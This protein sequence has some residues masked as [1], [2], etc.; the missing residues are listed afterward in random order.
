MQLNYRAT[1]SFY[2]GYQKTNLFTERTLHVTA[3]IFLL[4][5][6]TAIPVKVL[7]PSGFKSESISMI[8]WFLIV[9]PLSTFFMGGISQKAWMLYAG[10]SLFFLAALIPTSWGAPI[11]LLFTIPSVCFLILLFRTEPKILRGYGYSGMRVTPLEIFGMLITSALCVSIIYMAAIM[12]QKTTYTVRSP[13]TYL[14]QFFLIVPKYAM[15][16]GILYGVLMKRML[17][18]KFES[19]VSIV[20][21][22]IFIIILFL[23]EPYDV[24]DTGLVVAKIVA[25]ATV[26]NMILGMT[27]FFTRSVRPL[28]VAHALTCVIFASSSL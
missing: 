27:Y 12:L 17:G 9:F 15:V 26:L 7:V 24:G 25:W 20:L 10:F 8:P 23:T 18:L 19:P 13:L 2:D 1:D 28:L 22:V 6:I 4:F 16:W 5:A 14:V 21:N 11:C 3:L